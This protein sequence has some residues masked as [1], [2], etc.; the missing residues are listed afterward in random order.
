[1]HSYLIRSWFPGRYFGPRSGV[2]VF[3]DARRARRVAHG[4]ELHRYWTGRD[5]DED[6]MRHPGL[7]SSARYF[8]LRQSSVLVAD[9]AALR[10]EGLYT[11]PW[12]TWTPG[13]PD[14]LDPAHSQHLSQS[15]TT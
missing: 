5:P 10:R 12:T 7:E 14:P 1:M 15:D 3:D 6:E 2:F 11:V 9:E 8:L 4:L 13:P